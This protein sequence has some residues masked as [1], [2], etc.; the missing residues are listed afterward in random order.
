MKNKLRGRTDN[1]D[2]SEW[3]EYDDYRGKGRIKKVS[4]D[5]RPKRETKNWTKAWSEYGEDYDERDEFYANTKL[6]R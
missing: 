3:I 5:C 6:I 2:D 4:S 1:L